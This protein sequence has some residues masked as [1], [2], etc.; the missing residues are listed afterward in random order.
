MILWL[1]VNYNPSAHVRGYGYRN[2]FKDNKIKYIN[3]YNLKLKSD[4]LIQ[5]RTL[6]QFIYI[7]F[8]VVSFRNSYIIIERDLPMKLLRIFERINQYISLRSRIVY[9]FDDAMWLDEFIGEEKFSRV[10]S[11]AGKVICDNELQS[12]FLQEKWLDKQV[13][14]LP[15]LLPKLDKPFPVISS[16]DKKRCNICYIGTTSTLIFLFKYSYGIQLFLE[17]YPDSKLILLGKFQKSSLPPTLADKIEIRD[18]DFPFSFQNIDD[19]YLGLAPLIKG[20]KN[21]YYRGLQKYRVYSS[22]GIPSLCLNYGEAA[23]NLVDKVDCYLFDENDDLQ[24]KLEKIFDDKETWDRIRKKC[25]RIYDPD[26]FNQK[27]YRTLKNFI[28]GISKY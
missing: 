5:L 11:L 18:I 3:F 14:V 1:L 9:D 25:L 6:F 17:K 8:W 4:V 20:D 16:S 27:N 28:F 22:L 19:I 21:S 24:Y 23:L 7:L 15:G 13:L 12:R 10:I 2:F 26:L